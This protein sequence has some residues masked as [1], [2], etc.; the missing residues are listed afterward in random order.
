[1]KYLQAP[2]RWEFISKHIGKGD[3]VLC[4]AAEGDRDRE[5]LVCFR[6]RYFF[7]ILNKYPYATGHLMVVPYRHTSEISAIPADQAAEMWTLLNRSLAI[8]SA[9][10]KPN[11][12]NL[13]MN[14]GAAAGAGIK[15]HLHMHLVPRW[16]GDA[17]F[18]PLIGNTRVMSYDLMAVYDVLAEGF[19]R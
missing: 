3:C 9:Q 18:M 2:W 8:L 14:L 1:M 10:F 17:N 13:G 19:S 11:G 5:N 4:R 15:E 6:G 16:A 12:F 7:V